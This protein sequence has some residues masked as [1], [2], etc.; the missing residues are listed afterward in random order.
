MVCLIVLTNSNHASEK[1]LIYC[2][3]GLIADRLDRQPVRSSMVRSIV[4]IATGIA[5]LVMQHF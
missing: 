3:L 4:K 2:E 5:H 1:M